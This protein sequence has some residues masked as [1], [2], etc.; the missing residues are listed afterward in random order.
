MACGICCAL[1]ANE[2]NRADNNVS[3]FIVSISGLGTTTKRC[4]GFKTI[5]SKGRNVKKCESIQKITDLWVQYNTLAIL[6]PAM[7][8]CCIFVGSVYDKI[9]N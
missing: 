4:H 5:A 7:A 1:T 3:A 6:L 9:F 2:N 8:M